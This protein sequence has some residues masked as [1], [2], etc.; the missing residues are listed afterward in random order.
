MTTATYDHDGEERLVTGHSGRLSLLLSLGWLATLLGREALPPLLPDIIAALNITSS[1]AGVAL[2]LMWGL[3]ALMQYPSGRLADGLSRTTVLVVSLVILILGFVLL[4][5]VGSYVAFLFAVALIGIGAGLYFVPTRALLSDL[6]VERRAQ[7]FGIQMAAGGLGSAL[8]AGVAVAAITVATWQTAFLPAIVG[9]IVVF[10]FLH[11]WS[12]EPYVID[13]VSLDL[14]GTGSRVFATTELRW[15]VIAY[16][17]FAVTWSGVIGFLPT[18][19]RA[20]KALSP[21]LASSAFA[22]IF[23]VAIIIGPI[24]GNLGDRFDH[25]SVAA[26]ALTLGLI[27]L[28]AVIYAP[29]LPVILLGVVVFAAGLR[30]YPPVMQAYL[31][32]AFPDDSMG[33]DFGAIKAIYT[34]VGSLGPSYIGFVAQEATYV[35][36]FSGLV[37]ALLAAVGIILWLMYSRG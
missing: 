2:T 22:L 1:Q 12:H 17:L 25:T 28:A 5:V 26:A 6:F 14:R 32:D 4:S 13:R 29:S 19:L 33:G 16:S 18:F 8:A 9:L 37:V 10:A 23:I 34:G 11:R 3:Y 30:S 24:S 20:E 36:A 27:G 21:A 7:A 15:V 35:V 31:M